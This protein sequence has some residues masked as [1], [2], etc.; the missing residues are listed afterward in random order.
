MVQRQVDVLFSSN[1]HNRVVCDITVACVIVGYVTG[2]YPKHVACVYLVR[3]VQRE[4]VET[5]QWV[6]V[7]YLSVV[8][9]FRLG[10]VRDLDRI[11]CRVS[12]AADH[13]GWCSARTVERAI[14]PYL[15]WNAIPIFIIQLCYWKGFVVQCTRSRTDCLQCDV[16]EDHNSSVITE[17][18]TVTTE[19][20]EI[21]LVIRYDHP[22]TIIITG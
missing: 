19:S 7:V 20:Y 22:I 11:G 6:Y 12:V 18:R 2:Y 14:I 17:I 15:I 1:V 10:Q 8:N 16:G 4:V 13:V 5:G 3:D 9:A 21:L